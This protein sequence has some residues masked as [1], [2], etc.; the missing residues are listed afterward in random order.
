MIV[1]KAL[2]VIVLFGAL[3]PDATRVVLGTEPADRPT[4]GK[5][6]YGEWRILIKPDKGQEY[7][8]LI[9]SRGL[10]LFRKAG[11][12]MVGWWT[13][14]VG[15][16]YE[17]VTIWEY[18]DMAAFERAI[19]FL[20][21]E[22][23]FAEFVALRDPLLAG[24]QN[25]LLTLADAAEQPVLSDPSKFVVHEIHRVPRNKINDYLEFISTRGL[26]LLKHHG[27][28]PAGPWTVDVGK[29]SEVTYLFRFESLDERSRLIAR[30]SADADA[31]IYGDAI[32]RFVDEVTTRV[33]VPAPF[34]SPSPAKLVDH[35]LSS[36][37]LPHVE[38]LGGG[39]FAAGFSDRYGSANCGWVRLRESTLLVDLPHGLGVP[40]FLAEV[41]RI[42]GKPVRKLALTHVRAEDE[43]TIAALLNH[44]VNEIVTSPAIRD[45]LAALWK[46]ARPL[47]IKA[48]VATGPIGDDD[49]PVEL[50]SLDGAAAPGGAAIH[51]TRQRVLF[52]GPL[53]VNGPR[54]PLPGSNTKLWLSTLAKLESLDSERVVPGFG[55]WGG[56]EIVGRERRFLTELRQ[57]IAYLIAQGRSE[58][59]LKNE[60][61]IPTSDLVWMPYDTPTL[62]DREHVYRELTVPNA[63]FDGQPPDPLDPVPHALVLV[64]DQPHEPGH[65]IEGLRPVFEAAGVVPHFAV[66]VRALTAVNLSKVKL[67]VML[68]DGLQRPT[69]DRASNYEWMT[70][71]QQ[72]A[73]VRFVTNGGG[74][75]NLHNSM[76]IYPDDGP[77]LRLVGGRYIGH[78]PLERFRVEVV[79]A[80]H[81]ITRGVTAF[82]VADE[83]HTPPYDGSKVHLLL[84]NRSDD[85][86]V[87]AAGWAYEPGRGR[88]CYL[89][90]GHTRESLQHPMYRRLLQNAINWCLRRDSTGIAS[91]KH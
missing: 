27:F 44:G 17:Q 30:F 45:S 48:F 16:L 21:R 85:G 7:N 24:E 81:P 84:R 61:R 80:D 78:G 79:D 23:Q 28:R 9:K 38:A 69:D 59:S 37:L 83:Q 73:V 58:S 63:P 70:G 89:A 50:I 82:S 15:N 22:K 56:R 14:L 46:E 65:I 6:V 43:R 26:K 1:R 11:A 86:K 29:W 41:E 57:Q 36:P 39:A 60:V 4:S 72:Q 68:R 71:P 74:L 52:A 88:L 55:S 19:G 3:C 64:G 10:P 54:T 13:T 2:Y 42:A 12:R 76:G 49:V 87:A 33:L 5:K 91:T 25:R 90:N 75:L 34:A 18:D 77:Y 66:D 47:A 40:E 8:A 31:K 51:L 62:D 35:S 32:N 53:V 20:G 67:L